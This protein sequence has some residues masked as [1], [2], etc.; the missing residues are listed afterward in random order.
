MNPIG[1]AAAIGT[2]GLM[3]EIPP[4]VGNSSVVGKYRRGRRENKRPR[5]GDLEGSQQG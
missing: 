2:Q 4:E 1:E 3:K 5:V